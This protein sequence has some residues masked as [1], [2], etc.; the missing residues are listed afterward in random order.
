[1][2]G[3]FGHLSL[4]ASKSKT[5]GISKKIGWMPD[6]YVPDW[7]YNNEGDNRSSNSNLGGIG[8]TRPSKDIDII[9]SLKFSGKADDIH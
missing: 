2:V 1:M 9:S 5:L 7:I 8:E 3:T 4:N 6:Y